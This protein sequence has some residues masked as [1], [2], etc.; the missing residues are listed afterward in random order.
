MAIP[1]PASKAIGSHD[2][3]SH[4]AKPLVAATA[5]HDAASSANGG[6]HRSKAIAKS[7]QERRLRPAASSRGIWVTAVCR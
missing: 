3:P 7:G 1:P 4:Q 2:A 5:S 6:I